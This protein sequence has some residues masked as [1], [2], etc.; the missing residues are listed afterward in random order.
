MP[1]GSGLTAHSPAF[2]LCLEHSLKP[3]P[4]KTLFTSL[5]FPINQT[6]S[7]PLLAARVYTASSLRLLSFVPK[8]PSDSS[9]LVL[10]ITKPTGSCSFAW[11][12]PTSNPNGST[13]QATWAQASLASLFGMSSGRLSNEFFASQTVFLYCAS[14]TPHFY[15]CSSS[16]SIPRL[17]QN[18]VTSLAPLNSPKIHE[19]IS[20]LP[21]LHLQN[22][23]HAFCLDTRE[24]ARPPTRRH[25]PRQRSAR[26]ST[27]ERHDSSLG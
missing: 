22:Q 20:S 23:Q 15:L 5:G 9:C 10:G 26:P 6:T 2:Y 1:V 12:I 18:L 7:L 24:R 16:L 14:F 4:F 19:S 17:P 13:S 8:N 27:V 3:S 11:W 25:Q 21:K